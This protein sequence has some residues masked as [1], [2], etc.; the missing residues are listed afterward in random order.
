[1]YNG[2]HIAIHP[3]A[4]QA[5]EADGDHRAEGEDPDLRREDAF[6]DAAPRG[7]RGPHDGL[8]LGAARQVR[9]RRQRP[10]GGDRRD[11]AHVAGPAAE[12]E[13]RDR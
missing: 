10:P 2:H 6:E 5:A 8:L 12:T 4:V 1:M 13:N 9:R 3:A 7:R 11:R